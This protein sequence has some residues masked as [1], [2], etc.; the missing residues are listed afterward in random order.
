M[1]S[2]RTL[3]AS[4]P[5]RSAVDERGEGEEGAAC[6]TAN[7]CTITQ[8]TGTHMLSLFLDAIAIEADCSIEY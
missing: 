5:V 2:L 3:R 4:S 7:T 6:A 8:A 1:I